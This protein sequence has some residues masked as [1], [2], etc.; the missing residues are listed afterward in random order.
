MKSTWYDENIYIYI[1]TII[2]LDS[3]VHGCIFTIVYNGIQLYTIVYNRIQSY[4]NVFNSIQQ[5]TIVCNCIRLSTTVSILYNWLYIILNARPGFQ[6]YIILSSRL[7]IQNFEFPA[8]NSKLY[9]NNCTWLY[10][11]NRIQLYTIV[12]NRIQT[13][14][15]L[16]NS[17]KWYA[18]VDE[19]IQLY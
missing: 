2:I 17:I 15:I 14:T 12:Y 13:Y 6:S 7:G 18:I 11:Y 5:Y 1:Y 9:I 10:I 8:G 3:I 16:Y 4:T 19:C